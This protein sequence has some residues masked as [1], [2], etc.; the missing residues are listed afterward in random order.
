MRIPPI[1]ALPFALLYLIMLGYYD[2]Y[3]KLNT[4]KGTYELFIPGWENAWFKEILVLSMTAAFFVGL[5]KYF[6]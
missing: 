1:K 6:T 5:I 2:V 3:A 4:K